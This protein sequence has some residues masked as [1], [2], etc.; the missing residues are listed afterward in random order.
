M[1]NL[2]LSQNNSVENIKQTNK[3]IQ[4]QEKCGDGDEKNT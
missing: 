2:K 3:E 1:L 4:K